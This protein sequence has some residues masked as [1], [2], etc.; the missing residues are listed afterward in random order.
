LKA[1]KKSAGDPGDLVV[2]SESYLWFEEITPLTHSDQL[3]M[4]SNRPLIFMGTPFA[5]GL[6]AKAQT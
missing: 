2:D 1:I 5:W 4:R 6:R 3:C